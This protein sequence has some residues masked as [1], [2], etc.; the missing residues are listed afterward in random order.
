MIII[1]VIII[2][3]EIA[4]YIVIE[5]MFFIADGSNESRMQHGVRINPVV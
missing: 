4:Y 3:T 2:A 1:F 5:K